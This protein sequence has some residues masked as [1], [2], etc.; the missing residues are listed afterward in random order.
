MVSD[1]T[2]ELTDEESQ[3]IAAL[4]AARLPYP[5]DGDCFIGMDVPLAGTWG[6][7]DEAFWTGTERYQP[8]KD[9]ASFFRDG[10][11]KGER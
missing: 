10:G 5:L 1:P 3:T 7:E 11:Y 8:W 9:V 6:P 4:L 2:L